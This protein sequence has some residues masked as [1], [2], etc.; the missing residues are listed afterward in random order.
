MSYTVF[1]RDVDSATIQ[2]LS[3]A[4]AGLKFDTIKGTNTSSGDVTDDL[5]LPSSLTGGILVSWSSSNT[6]VVSNSGVVTPSASSS[7]T[8]VL[9][10]VLAYNGGI[11]TS[12]ITVTVPVDSGVLAQLD[13]DE[14]TESAILGINPSASSVIF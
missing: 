10:A 6:S 4:A 7:E 3:T 8:V 9:T 5:V 2:A 13:A 11:T 12:T 14:L 1:E